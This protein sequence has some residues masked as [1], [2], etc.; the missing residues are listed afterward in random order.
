MMLRFS[1]IA[2]VSVGVAMASGQDSF[3]AVFHADLHDKMEKKEFK[4][5]EGQTLPYRLYV[6]RSYDK[7]QKYPV[8]LFLHGAGERGDDNQAQLVH[9]GFLDFVAADSKAAV[10]CIVVVPQCAAKRRWSEVDWDKKTPPITP[11]NPSQPMQL[12]LGLLDQLE[13]EYSIDPERRYV[14]GISMGGFGTFDIC[15]RRPGYF[16]AAVPI[17]GAL[18]VTKAKTVASTAFWIFHGG[19]DTVV[20]TSLSRKAYK[21]LK[22]AGAD[23]K[24]TEYPG[25]GHNSWD[26]ALRDQEMIA[27]VLKHRRAADAAKK[28]AE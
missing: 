10:P 21:A 11:K 13:K 28:P 6:P 15:A 5:A 4:G 19:A 12:V 20:A 26:L 8:L 7:S 17:C 3:G 14:A 24:Y 23:V 2:L 1:A 22:E 16:A 9:D 25:V 27:W 18:D